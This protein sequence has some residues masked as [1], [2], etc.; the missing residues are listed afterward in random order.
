MN[1]R[2]KVTLRPRSKLERV[3]ELAG[4]HFITPAQPKN[5]ILAQLALYYLL[6]AETPPALAAELVKSLT[7]EGGRLDGRR[8]YEL[9][10]SALIDR[11]PAPRVDETLDA[12]RRVGRL[13]LESNLENTSKSDL[14]EARRLLVGLPRLHSQA[15]DLLLLSAGA[16]A[17]V[18]PTPSAMR[19]A[20]R[21]GYPGSDYAAIARSLDAEVPEVDVLGVAWRAHHALKQLGATLCEKDHPS[22]ASCPLIRACA[23]RGEGVD[24]A[25]RPMM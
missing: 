12:L 16:Q 25:S 19:V 8:L 3:L 5:G 11:C 23:Y 20:T 15:I 18:A 17:L 21:L 6:V 14:D 4:S 7:G 22:C 24:P 10:K 13:A 9:D 2:S 1:L